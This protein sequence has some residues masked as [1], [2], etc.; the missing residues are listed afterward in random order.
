LIAIIINPISGGASGAGRTRAELARAIV[1]RT[2]VDAVVHVTERSGHGRELAESAVVSG[3][4]RV[5]AWGGDGTINEIASVLAFRNVP[6][7]IVPAGSGNGLARE[8][9]LPFDSA[10]ALGKALGGT[11]HAI[12]VGEI[13]QRF[14]VNVAG[15]GLDAYVAARFNDPRNVR[16]G[17]RAYVAMTAAALASYRP[18]TYDIATADGRVTK[19][20]LLIVLANGTEF[21]NRILIARGARVDDGLLDLVVVEER[22]RMATLCRVPWLLTRSIH[23]VPV[24]STR[25][26]TDVRIESD[27]PMLFH[28][29]GE[30]VQGGRCVTA[31]IHPG[32]LHVVA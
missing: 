20:A 6:M 30:P 31:R 12:D 11:P 28:V 27:E 16:R 26:V 8:L 7:G 13:E 23:R 1:E 17:P 21:G 10:S 2:R 24:W 4:D 22:S 14:F 32:A 9:A 25:P 18:K 3:A 29:D 15:I 5:V 19:T